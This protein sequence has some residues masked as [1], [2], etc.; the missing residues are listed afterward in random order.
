MNVTGDA[1]S[2]QNAP[3]ERHLED[4]WGMPLAG[5]GGRVLFGNLM[6]LKGSLEDQGMMSLFCLSHFR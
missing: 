4:L 3:A 6:N 2:V 1:T 5:P